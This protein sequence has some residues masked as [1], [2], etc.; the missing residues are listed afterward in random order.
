[1]STYLPPPNLPEPPFDPH[2]LAI[3]IHAKPEAAHH[4]VFVA[5]ALPENFGGHKEA[6]MLAIG[7]LWDRYQRNGL[8][9]AFSMH[10]AWARTDGMSCACRTCNRVGF[11]I[12]AALAKAEGRTETYALYMDQLRH[13]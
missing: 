1:M 10:L 9:V 12:S 11:M 6:A 4:P 2:L 3:E 7:K 5:A 13:L 8:T